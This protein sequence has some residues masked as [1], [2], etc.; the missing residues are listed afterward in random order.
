LL[1]VQAAAER[2]LRLN[3]TGQMTVQRTLRRFARL[4][5]GTV[6]ATLQQSVP[7]PEVQIAHRGRLSMALKAFCRENRRDVL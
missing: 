1:I 6:L 7:A 3:L 2:H 4:Q 5:P